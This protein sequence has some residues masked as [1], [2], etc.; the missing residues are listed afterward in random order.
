M[1]RT[2]CACRAAFWASASLLCLPA[3]AQQPADQPGVLSIS[4]DS[5]S[6]AASLSSRPLT[7]HIL[8]RERLDMRQSGSSDTADLLS[9]L[10]GV[11]A[12]TGGG[13]SSMPAIRGLSEQRLTLLVDGQPIDSACPNDMNPP[14]SYTDP[15]TIQFVTVITGVSP[16]SLG[17]DSIG[18]VIQVDSAPP[19]FAIDESLLIAGKAS[20]FFRTNGRGL[21]GA[22]SLTAASQSVSATYTG[23]YTQSGNIQ[24]GGNLGEVRSTEYAKTDQALALAV[25][26]GAS[27]FEARGGFQYSPRE[28][29]PNQHMDMTSNRSWFWNG[30]YQGAFDWGRLDV[31]SGYRHT[32]HEMNFLDDKGGTANGG[33]PMVTRTQSFTAGVK[34]DLYVSGRDTLRLGADYHHLALDDRWPAVPGNPMMG[35]DDFIN[36][37]DATRNRLGLFGEWEAR[38]ADNVSTVAGLRFD[39][40]RMNSAEVQPYGSGMMHRADAMAAA[41]FNAADRKRVDNNWS[42]SIL[43]SYAPA[44]GVKL[45]MGYAHKLRSPNLYERFAWGRGRMSS[46]MIGW[47]GDGNGYVGNLDLLPE[48][49]DTFSAALALGGTAS[50]WTLKIAPY[51]THVNDYIDARFV[52]AFQD[53]TG[54]PTGFVQLQFANTSAEFVG[55]DL[56]GTV[57][58]RT[59]QNGDAT[60]LTGA[61]SWLRGRNPD[62]NTPLYHQMPA[63]LK[64]GVNH[65]DGALELGAELGLVADKTRVDTVRNEPATD[66]YALVDLRLG[67]RIGDVRLSVEA[68]NLFD[69]GY[70]LPLGGRSIGDYKATGD[71]RPVP[72]P[73]RSVN[74]GMS[75][76]F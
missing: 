63:T 73:G 23:S 47:Y 10:P 11:S 67:Y 31:R 15:Q 62:A 57:A 18:G 19:R 50:G 65:V 21:G 40:V 8:T 22:F 29:F 1:S 75:T 37:N 5:D 4:V 64:L 74:V 16:V 45:E 39:Q 41:A 59:A 25:Q 54:R 26:R 38:W 24:A 66:A 60:R 61:F 9:D 33:M 3:L 20:G 43:A 72:G 14:L 17:G 52:Q 51:Y 53:G 44:D 68:L 71:L 12:R 2:S 30:R 28:G 48:R 7:T 35:P 69:K 27:L 70:A 56:S 36:V 42:G 76:S 6:S 13:F 55:V 32:N 34:L 58:L 49:A 46:S